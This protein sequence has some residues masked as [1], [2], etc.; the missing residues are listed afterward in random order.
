MDS[1]L[2]PEQATQDAL[3]A[4]KAAGLGKEHKRPFTVTSW[5]ER[6]QAQ[7]RD[8]I[9][10]EATVRKADQ[11][12]AIRALILLPGTEVYSDQARTQVTIWRH[13]CGGPH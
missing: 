13:A 1:S 8:Y 12:D 10:T 11:D 2:T 7:D 4:L 9:R 5:R 3:T 6:W